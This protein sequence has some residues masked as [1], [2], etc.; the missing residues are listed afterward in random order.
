MK[1]D[2]MGHGGRDAAGHGMMGGM[3]MNRAD[4]NKD[5]T[6]SKAEFTSTRLAHFDKI[7]ANHDGKVTPEERKAARKAMRGKM[8]GKRGMRHHDGAMGDGPPPPP[9]PAA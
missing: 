6:I 9:P 8:D 5:A 1:H 7:D 4:A 2:G 3:M